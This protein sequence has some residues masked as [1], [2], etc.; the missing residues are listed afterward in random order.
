MKGVSD[1]RVF[2]EGEGSQRKR[3]KKRLIGD[4]LLGSATKTHLEALV[5]SCYSLIIISVEDRSIL[6]GVGDTAAGKYAG[7]EQLLV[8]ELGELQYAQELG[9]IACPIR[10]A[11]YLALLGWAGLADAVHVA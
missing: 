10:R 5:A 2:Q 7:L 4:E 8:V 6:D 3:C 11:P 9:R 1:S